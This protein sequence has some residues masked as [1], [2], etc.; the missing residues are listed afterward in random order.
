MKRGRIARFVRVKGGVYL[1]EPDVMRL[2]AFTADTGRSRSDLLREAVA[3]LLQKHGYAT[4]T[5]SSR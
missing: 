5:R 3:D 1:P 4:T 2:E